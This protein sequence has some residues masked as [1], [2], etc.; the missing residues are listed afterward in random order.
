MRDNGYPKYLAH[1]AEHEDLKRRVVQY[2][3]DFIAGRVTL[4]VELMQFISDWLVNHIAESDRKL[5]PYLRE[6][7]A[8]VVAR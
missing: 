6:K 2:Q 5:A 1:R 4:T 7:A 3:E 8:I